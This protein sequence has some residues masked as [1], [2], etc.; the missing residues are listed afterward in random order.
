LKFDFN[1]V[2]ETFYL[3]A[4]KKKIKVDKHDAAVSPVAGVIVDELLGWTLVS[5]RSSDTTFLLRVVLLLEIT[6]NIFDFSLIKNRGTI[7]CFLS[8][9]RGLELDKLTIYSTSV[10]LSIYT[11]V[12]LK[13]LRTINI[14]TPAKILGGSKEKR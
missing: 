3:T 7:F 14:V 12:L 2:V 1:T 10:Y 6:Y 8:N 4:S 11:L 9:A 5:S 13:T